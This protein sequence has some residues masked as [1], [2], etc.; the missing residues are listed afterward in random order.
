ML[1]KAS[2]FKLIFSCLGQSLTLIGYSNEIFEI[3]EG[4]QNI[5]DSRSYLQRLADP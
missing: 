3:A 2:Y 5:L 1:P 4:R